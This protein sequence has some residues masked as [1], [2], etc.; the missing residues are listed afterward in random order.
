MLVWNI[1]A[2]RKEE[3]HA[4][5][6][7]KVIRGI[8]SNPESL[9]RDVIIDAPGAKFLQILLILVCKFGHGSNKPDSG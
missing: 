1:D 6:S 9:L 7:S 4:Q 8:S 5:N 2:I 3:E